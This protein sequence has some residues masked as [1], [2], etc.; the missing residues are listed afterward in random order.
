VGDGFTTPPPVPSGIDHSSSGG[1]PPSAD[2]GA[3][4]VSGRKRGGWLSGGAVS[5]LSGATAVASNY[6]EKIAANVAGADE[7]GVRGRRTC[8]D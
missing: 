1:A 4:S 8:W 5:V 3:G 7:V 2:G 6:L